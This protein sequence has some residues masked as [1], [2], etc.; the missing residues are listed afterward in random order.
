VAVC[1]FK[2]SY[3]VWGFHW[4]RDIINTMAELFGPSFTSDD[5]ELMTF[6]ASPDHESFLEGLWQKFRPYLKA[7][8]EDEFR[9][10]EAQP[11]PRIWEMYLTIALGEQKF[12]LSEKLKEGPDIKLRD[13]TIW[14]E[15][16]ASTDGATGNEKIHAPSRVPK[17]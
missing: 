16:V 17:S 11:H 8:Q 12:T 3:L 2:Y 5:R 14:V 7:S 15:A 9:D 13:P 10:L 1:R 6:L 4:G